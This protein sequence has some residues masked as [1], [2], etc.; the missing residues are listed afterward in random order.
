MAREAGV[1]RDLRVNIPLVLPAIVNYCRDKLVSAKMEFGVPIIGFYAGSC[2]PTTQKNEPWAWAGR[3]TVLIYGPHG[4]QIRKRRLVLAGWRYAMIPNSS[5]NC[6]Q[7]TNDLE[8]A[9]HEALRR[10]RGSIW[11]RNGAG[12][13]NQSG[14]DGYR[15]MLYITYGPLLPGWTCTAKAE[16][17]GE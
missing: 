8:K 9:L 16:W 13:Q 14:R 6:A 5:S 15:S 17:R 12:G 4:E 3:D 10:S 1:D 11:L 2:Q 7:N